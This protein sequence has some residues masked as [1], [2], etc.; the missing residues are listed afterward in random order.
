MAWI[1]PI[2]NWESND[3]YNFDDLNRVENNTSYVAAFLR[4]IQYQIPTQTIVTNRDKTSIDFISGI[5]R[6]E[7]NI[8]QLKN[9][10]VSPPGYQPKK[11]WTVGIGFN[12]NDANRLESNLK[13]LYDWAHLAKDNLRYCGTFVCGGDVI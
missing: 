12:H 10:F 6:V 7:N 13:L 2:T 5:N 11:I 1:E 8:E 4:S 3:N 9:A